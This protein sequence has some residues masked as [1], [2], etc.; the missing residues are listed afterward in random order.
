MSEERKKIGVMLPSSN[1]TVE[2]DFQRIVPGHVSI[3]GARMWACRGTSQSMGRACGR[4]IVASRC[5]SA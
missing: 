4:P 3:H 5:S 2:Y 1:T